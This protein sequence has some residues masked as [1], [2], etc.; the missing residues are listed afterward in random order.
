MFY[1]FHRQ[2]DAAAVGVDTDDFCLDDVAGV[3]DVRLV[4]ERMVAELGAVYQARRLDAEV[5]E[6]A[7]IDDVL[8]RAANDGPDLEISEGQYVLAG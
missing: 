5:D 8:D 4:T 6:G 3:D 1:F 7:E 2:A